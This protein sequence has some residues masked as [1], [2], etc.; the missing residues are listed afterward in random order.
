[1]LGAQ[2]QLRVV[3]SV[4]LPP[5]FFVGDRVEMR[6]R[7]EVPAG[8]TVTAPARQLQEP[9][10][11]RPLELP[12]RGG[13]GDEGPTWTRIDGIEV[14]DRRAPGAAG[15]VQVRVFF[16]PLQPGEGRLPEL[17]LGELSV[18]E[19]PFLT[20]SVREREPTLEF[21][22]LRGQLLAPYTRLRLAL[23]GLTFVG[24]PALATFGSIRALR[25]LR[26]LRERRRRRRPAQRARSEL[27]K[28]DQGLEHVETEQLFVD[29]A[30]I[31]KGYLGERFHVPT[32][33][34]TTV[35]IA[36]MLEAVGV[37][38]PLSGR[39]GEVLRIA[40]RAKFSGRAGRR[41]VARSSLNKV[42]DIVARVEELA[43]VEP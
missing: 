32:S 18:P 26:R 39:V 43:D 22:P 16:A 6:L 4:L 8:V 40:D 41:T 29:L 25:G 21:R 1:M 31:L 38:D 23:T 36:G 13:G 5:R 14:L 12:G 20:A 35:E 34:A 10:K 19:Q 3:E 27:R 30:Q 2:E 11:A 15:E 24:V 7:L 28:L 42:R 9:G 33:S 37:P 17:A